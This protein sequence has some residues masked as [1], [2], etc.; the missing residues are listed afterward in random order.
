MV[1]PR[2]C[3]P[4]TLSQVEAGARRVECRHTAQCIT[5]AEAKRWAAFDC[6][7]CGDYQAMTAA[8]CYAQLDGLAALLAVVNLP[9]YPFG[10][11]SAD[12][13]LAVAAH[14]RDRRAYY[15][16]SWRR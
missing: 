13:D 2:E 8:E 11:P 7:A 14:R 5:I 6:L 12:D 4:L 1:A 16:G 3:P 9:A 10:E 15:C